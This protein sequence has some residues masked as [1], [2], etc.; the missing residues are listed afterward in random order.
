MYENKTVLI[1]GGTGSWGHELRGELAQVKMKR[2]FNDDRLHFHIGDVRDYDAVL[3]AMQRVN[4]VFHL[5]ALKHV[6]VCEDHPYEAVR[7]NIEGTRNICRAADYWCV[8]KVIDVSTDKA[9]APVN[10]YGMT[11]AVGER[12]MIHANRI[13]P[14]EFICI[15]GGNAIGSNGSA[16]P[17]FI[18][19]V[20]TNNRITLTDERMT[21]YF[22]TLKEA[23]GLIF[24]ATEIGVGGEIFVMKM[25]AFYMKTIAEV[26]AQRYGNEDT[27]IVETGIRPGEKLDEVLISKDEA[28]LAYRFDDD[29]YLIVPD[30]M[31]QLTKHY[32]HLEKFGEEEYSSATLL[33]DHTIALH[34]L[35]TSG[36]IE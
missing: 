14:T 20:K 11:K 17:L 3:D 4:I 30:T 28:R 21:R 9:V 27:E 36:F 25:P 33:S 26:I 24:K 6:P 23:V 18:N 22:M 35:T 29:Y 1:T 19:Q 10:L 7:T 15:R 2:H 5:A 8:E 31:Q 12:L 32:E 13:G 34:A 16:I